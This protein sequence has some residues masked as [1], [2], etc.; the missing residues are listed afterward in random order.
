MPLGFGK[1]NKKE[2]GKGVKAANS[3]DVKMLVELG[4]K[5]NPEVRA[6]V[7]AYEELAEEDK[8]LFKL[9]VE[10][11]Q[12][13]A[14]NRVEDRRQLQPLVR[15]LMRTLLEDYPTILDNADIR[16]LMNRDYCKNSLSLE[17]SG[18]PLLRRVEVG[19][20]GSD[21]DS[22]DRY[23]AKQY[24]RKFYV[25]NKWWSVHHLT[26][27]QSLLQ[28]VTQL[29]ERNP[30]HPGVPALEHHKQVLQDYISY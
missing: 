27:A 20:K 23:W 25:C 17:L 12:A 30:D 29:A 15:R 18:F 11:G 7:S 19:R 6:L 13:T 1:S 21:N 4:L 5:R 24:A 2:I 28:F 9:A 10:Y 3:K 14:D 26:N 22:H 8:A 16:N